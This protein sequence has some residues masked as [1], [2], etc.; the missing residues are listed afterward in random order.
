M[1]FNSGWYMYSFFGNTGLELGL[2]DDGVTNYCTWNST[3]NSIKGADVVN[4]MMEL[5]SSPAFVNRAD[6]DLPAALASGKVIAAISGVW[7][8][9]DVEKAF[10]SDYGACKLPTYQVAGK[11]VQICL[12]YT[13]PS[14]RDRG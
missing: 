8:S 6:G 5:T 1:E 3:D 7:N 13:S 9:T 14:P 4:R 12:L 11:Q 10:G 2:N